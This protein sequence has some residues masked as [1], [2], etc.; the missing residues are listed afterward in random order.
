MAEEP[1]QTKASEEIAENPLA[2]ADDE[3]EIYSNIS[4]RTAKRNELAKSLFGILSPAVKQCDQVVRGVFQSQ[5]KVLNEIANL[6]KTLNEWQKKEEER[7]QKQKQ[8]TQSDGKTV[9]VVDDRFKE[10][11]QKLRATRQKLNKLSIQL[12]MIHHR[13]DVVLYYFNF[14]CC[15]TLIY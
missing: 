12:G 9:E 13:L 7:R 2:K 3:E 11:L 5:Q 10:Y 15:Y 4:D 8:E 14:Y 6:E 1:E